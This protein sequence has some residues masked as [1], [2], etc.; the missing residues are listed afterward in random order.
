MLANILNVK[1]MNFQKTLV[2]LFSVQMSAGL[3]ADSMSRKHKVRVIT[4]LP[5]DAQAPRDNFYR[6]PLRN[7]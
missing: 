4:P 1:I 2:L 6:V 3:T 7:P 5:M